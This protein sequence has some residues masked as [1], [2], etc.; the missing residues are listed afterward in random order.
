MKPIVIALFGVKSSGKSTAGRELANTLGFMEE[1]FAAPIKSMVSQAFDFDDDA[2]YGVSSQ[3]ERQFPQY[4]FIGPCLSCGDP[5]FVVEFDTAMCRGCGATYPRH[6]NA[7]IACQ[8]LGTEWGR[9]LYEN[10]WVDA[11]FN[12]IE[13]RL[14]TGGPDR[15][16]ITDGR[17]ENEVI[18]SRARGAYCILLTRNPNPEV[19]KS[20]WK[21]G[22]TH[23]SEKSLEIPRDLFHEIFDN[24]GMNVQDARRSITAVAHNAVRYMEAK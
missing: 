23:P 5:N 7:R 13:K 24:A 22:T 1:S 2:L 16:V 3:R 18:R 11:A 10:V 21:R 20:W 12:R 14:K 6:I 8:T 17:F 4:P 15:V 19:K 9:R